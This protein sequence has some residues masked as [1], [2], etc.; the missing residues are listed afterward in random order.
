M[1]RLGADRWMWEW[2]RQRNRGIKVDL[3][4]NF[5]LEHLDGGMVVPFTEMQMAFK[6]EESYIPPTKQRT[7]RMGAIYEVGS[8]ALGVYDWEMSEEKECMN[9]Q[10]LVMQATKE[11]CKDHQPVQSTLLRSLIIFNLFRVELV[12][13]I[14]WLGFPQWNSLLQ[15]PFSCFLSSSY[16]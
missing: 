1:S 9:V 3:Y 15:S 4:L 14:I 2:R 5:W 12:N 6:K 7:H 16:L 8:W 10:R 11:T 13:F